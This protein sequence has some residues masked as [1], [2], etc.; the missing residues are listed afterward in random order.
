MWTGCASASPSRLSPIVKLPAGIKAMSPGPVETVSVAPTLL[1][2]P[3][4]LLTWAV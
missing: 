2:E 3:T 4:E 1:T